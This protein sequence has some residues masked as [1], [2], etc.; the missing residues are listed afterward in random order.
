LSAHVNKKHGRQTSGSALLK[1]SCATNFECGDCGAAFVRHDSYRSHQRQHEKNKMAQ[2][3]VSTDVPVLPET[4]ADSVSVDQ[5]IPPTHASP[6]SPASPVKATF[7]A[8][9]PQSPPVAHPP[10]P[11]S[12]SRYLK[13]DPVMSSALVVQQQQQRPQTVLLASA[14]QQP[15]LSQLV[16]FKLDDQ[17]TQL[18]QAQP[19]VQY[20]VT[21]DGLLQ[22][23][24]PT[25]PA[26]A[27][28]QPQQQQ[29]R[30]FSPVV[31][32]EAT[33]VSNLFV[34]TGN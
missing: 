25:A 21:S 2:T 16:P 30:Y 24:M 22:P 10:P 12:A 1:T 26:V 11:P 29:V 32:S 8:E 31:T 7:A 19:G 20:L 9:R 14:D 3:V 34:R 23:L 15:A 5:E 6:A 17:P 28:Q 4:S 13:S 18:F 27:T 33:V